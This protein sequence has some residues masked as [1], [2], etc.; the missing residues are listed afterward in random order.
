M[1][2]E[3]SEMIRLGP[4]HAF[5]SESLGRSIAVQAEACMR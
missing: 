5:M 3:A 1:R 2:D 4:L